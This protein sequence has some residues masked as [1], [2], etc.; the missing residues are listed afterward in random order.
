M[1]KAVETDG[2]WIIILGTKGFVG[3][4]CLYMALVLPAALFTWRFPARLWNDPRLAAGSVAAVLLALYVT[5]CLLNGFV[6]II[7]ITLAGALMGLEP[8][9]LRMKAVNRAGVAAVTGMS[10]LALADHNRS[11]GRAL[12][13]EGRLHE[14]E[15]V[16]RRTLD[17]L[18]GLTAAYP[19]DAGLQQ[20]C[21]D[22]TN[23]LVWLWANYD[24]GHRDLSAA[25]AM[26]ATVGRTVP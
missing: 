1:A 16:W 21:R 18:S 17:L 22:C 24:T 10:Q 6:N 9:I 2:L 25:V 20:R 11:L 4:T 8:G 14:A 19:N 12:K 3:L 15:A 5:D 13:A 23:D 26:A 7:Y